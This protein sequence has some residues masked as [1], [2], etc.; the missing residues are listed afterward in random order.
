MASSRTGRCPATRPSG[1]VM[2]PLTLSSV[3]LVRAIMCR[4]L[5]TWTLSPLLWTRCAPAL[6]GQC[7]KAQLL[8]GRHVCSFF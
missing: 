6:T 1:G 3:R 5:S 7:G 2:T 4:G 8:P